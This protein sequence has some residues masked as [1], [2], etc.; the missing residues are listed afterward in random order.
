MHEN[1]ITKSRF[2]GLCAWSG[3][4]DDG[5][6]S[7]DHCEGEPCRVF[8]EK[9][10]D[11]EGKHEAAYAYPLRSSRDD[12]PALLFPCA[13]LCFKEPVDPACH[14]RPT[15]RKTDG[16]QYKEYCVRPRLGQSGDSQNEKYPPKD[17]VK[18]LLH[19]VLRGEEN[20]CA[21]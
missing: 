1:S 6:K 12:D 19:D 9:V 10:V 8:H 20:N 15:F 18:K 17:K 11:R 13:K 16:R 2:G 14:P 21:H 7:G 5:E 4:D 3:E